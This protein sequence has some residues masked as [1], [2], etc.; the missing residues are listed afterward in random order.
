MEQLLKDN[1]TIKDLE[2]IKYLCNED[3]EINDI[4]TK[5]NLRIEKILE[6]VS[7][8][9][10]KEC[11]F[12]KKII[13]PAIMLQM[14]SDSYKYIAYKNKKDKENM[15][16]LLLKYKERLELELKK[17]KS[18]ITIEQIDKEI[19]VFLNKEGTKNIS[20]WRKCSI[21]DLI[22]KPNVVSKLKI[23][24]NVDVTLKKN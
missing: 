24:D 12:L 6:I 7:T 10:S 13:P 2:D 23:V 5:G 15:E 20:D 11:S 14:V 4:F 1:I 9:D 16:K 22:S 3:N 21:I 18:N 19:N 8:K 17:N